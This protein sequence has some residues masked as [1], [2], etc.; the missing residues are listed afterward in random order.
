MTSIEFSPEET[1]QTIIIGDSE[2][3]EVVKLRNGHVVSIKPIFDGVLT[4]MTVYTDQRVYTF[5]LASDGNISKGNKP[6][7]SQTFRIAF[8][9]PQD[10][11]AA[12]KQV[13]EE[14]LTGPVSTDYVASGHAPF[15]PY[16]VRDDTWRT[17]FVLPPNTPR[18]VI[19]RVGPRGEEQLVNSRTRDNLVIVDGTSDV[20]VMRLGNSHV[21]IAR[22]S[23]VDGVARFNAKQDSKTVARALSGNKPK[24]VRSSDTR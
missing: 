2:S 1:I 21:C 15:R 13:E 18:P 6:G 4:N 20:W 11:E 9:Y 8:D 24:K 22:A 19:Y 17:Y 12:K 3:W 16:Q 14:R 7:T 10:R 23:A 5:E